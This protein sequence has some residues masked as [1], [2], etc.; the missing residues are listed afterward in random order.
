MFALTK[1]GGQCMAAPDV[2]KTPIPP[3]GPVPIPYPNIAMPLMGNPCALKVMICG[4]PALTKASKIPLSNGNQPGVAGGVV[5]SKIMGPTE[6]L[7]GS[8][9]VKI[10]GNPAIKL[11][12]PTKQNDGNIVGAVLV[13]SQFQVMV[14]G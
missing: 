1:A 14:M 10:E 4:M 11:G 3:A 7:L 6:F 9:K 13:P 8:L 2:C 5:S 12:D